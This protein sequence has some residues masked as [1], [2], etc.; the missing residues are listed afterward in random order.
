MHWLVYHIASGHAFFSGVLLVALAVW[1]SLSKRR[2]LRRLTGVA[3]LVGV[4]A[5][6]LS[7]TALPSWLYAVAGVATLAWIASAFKRLADW[8]RPAANATLVALMLAEGVEFTHHQTPSP[9]PASSRSMAVIGDSVTAGM[10]GDDRSLT[11]PTLLGREHGLEIQDLSHVGETT[12]S[13][14][15]R[16]KAHTITAPLVVVEIG[17]NDILGT[18]D[19]ADFAASLDA[20]LTHLSKPGR[21]IMMFELPL[22]PLSHAYG[23]AQRT[24]AAKHGVLLIPKRVFL[25]IIAGS[26]STLDSIHLTQE[27]H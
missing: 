24:L 18:T 14:L 23:R 2:F 7:S 22:I 13:A 1:A 11:W 4:I 26:D 27:G 10:G 6:V 3:F 17:G 12:A 15:K 16:A 20:L 8:R 19:A 21:Q 5:I 25:S 9:R